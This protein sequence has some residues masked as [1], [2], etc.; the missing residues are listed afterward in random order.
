MSKKII[1]RIKAL[2]IGR[3]RCALAFRIMV[4]MF[5][6][7]EFY[8]VFFFKYTLKSCVTQ[9]SFSSSPT[10][11]AISHSNR[12]YYVFSLHIVPFYITI[13]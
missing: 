1:K 2:T 5:N 10:Q 4:L 8:T 12:Q 11:A 7:N 9:M 13:M 3:E 6:T